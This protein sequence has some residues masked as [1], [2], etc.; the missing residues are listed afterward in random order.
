MDKRYKILAVDDEYLNTQLIK[1]VLAEE[2][3]ILTTCSGYEAIDLVRQ[4]TPDLI[5]LDIVMPDLSGFEVCKVIRADAEYDTIPIIFLTAVESQDAQLYGLELGG[6]DFLTKPVNH[7]LLKLRVRNQLLLKEQRDLLSHQKAE[8]AELLAEQVAQNDHLLESKAA[9]LQSEEMYRI[10]FEQSPDG[11]VL[12]SMPDLKA[13]KCNAAALALHGYSQEEFASLTVADIEA[14]LDPVEIAHT[15]NVLVRDG[16]SRFDSVHRTKTGELRHL[17]VSLKTVEL[18]GQPMIL[19]IH[20]DISERKQIEEI[21]SYLLQM[22]SQSTGEDFFESLARYLATILGMDYV[23]IDRLQGD[24]LSAKTLA[25]Y[26]DG[27]FEDNVEYTLKDTPC[28]D[29]VGKEICVFP[30][31]V[32][33]L[34]PKDEALQDLQA[35]SYLGTTLW[36]FDMKPIGLI[37]VIG[38]KELSRSRFAESVLKLVSIRA[39][40]ELERRQVEE[41]AHLLQQ[42][43]QQTQKL[44][45]LGVLAGGIAHDFNNILAIII[46]YC[47]LIKMDYAEAE[48]T[49]PHIEKAAERAAVLCRQM[50]EYAGKAH[51]VLTQINVTALVDEM[52]T[53]LKSTTSQNVTI[54]PDLATALPPLKGDA[55][56][57]RQVVM[58]LIIN[59]SEAIGEA[60]GVIKI[61][62]ECVA[63]GA[64]QLETDHLGTRIPVGGYI[65]MEVSDTGCGM[66]DETKRRIFEPFYSTKFSGRGLGMS[67]TLGIITAHKGAL[68]LASVPGQGSTFKIYLPVQHNGS[69]IEAPQQ[70]VKSAPWKGSGTILL[71]EDE[72]QVLLIVKT[73]LQVMGFTIVEANNGR[74][75]LEVYRKNAAKISLVVTDMGMPV[76]DGY[77]LFRELKAL[78]PKLP[79]IITSGYGDAVIT[80]RIPRNDIAG[81][82]SKPY[83]FDQLRDVLKNVVEG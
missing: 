37:A 73:M 58:N 43:F 64:A 65:C 3:D 30:R 26:H 77:E 22:G 55:S 13:V 72:E 52:V 42:Q 69:A 17:I 31:E 81:L 56:Q 53:M 24:R 61:S 57:L 46:G 60:Q 54:I 25:V 82:V 9:L 14:T 34:F 33:N 49:I 21:Q 68:Q 10:L 18:E 70:Q 27:A 36:S 78:N 5:L 23:C 71:V 2:Y 16:V 15:R 76:M 74:E 29:V 38:R 39:A 63:I 20:R 28:G 1:S 66:D 8:L 6:I 59:A 47:S 67:A 83:R 12:W 75:A 44:E 50:L 40:G 45:S 11:I 51:S 80:S 62:L 79:I 19:D 48:S 35:E 32:R 7:V 4:Y 41:E